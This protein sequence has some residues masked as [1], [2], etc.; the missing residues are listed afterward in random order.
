MTRGSP[1]EMIV[2]KLAAPRT[3]AG[4]PKDGVL[5]RLN[6]SARSSI[7]RDPGSRTRRAKPTSTLRHE[8]PRTG[9]RDALPS[10]N[11][12]AT[13]NAVTSNQCAGVRWADRRAGFDTR[14]GR[15]TPKPA[16][17]LKLVAWVTAIG[18]PDCAVTIPLSVQ[19][20]A[21]QP[22]APRGCHRRPCPAG[23]SHTADE[24]NTFGMSPVDRSRSRR[25]SKL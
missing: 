20:D 7:D 17:A 24:T 16:N 8:G 4:A 14:L 15:C 2:P 10:V 13:V 19:S 11:C 23:S 9:V 6:A 5:S 25:R 22:S 3:A 12:G 1:A 21:I 18:T